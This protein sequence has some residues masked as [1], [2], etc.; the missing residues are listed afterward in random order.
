MLQQMTQYNIPPLPKGKC[1]GLVVSQ[2]FIQENE[3]IQNIEILF[4]LDIFIQWQIE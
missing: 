3:K 4:I 2:V 1:L